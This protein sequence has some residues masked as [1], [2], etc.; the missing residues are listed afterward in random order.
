MW[1]VRYRELIKLLTIADLKLRYRSSAIGFAW[2]LLN[3]LLM[4]LI[5]YLVFHGVFQMKEN[6]FALYLLI[7][8]VAWRFLANGTVCSMGAVVHKSSLVTKLF[9]PRQILVFSAVLSCFVSSALEFLV[10]VVLLLLFGVKLSAY[11]FCFPLVHMVYFAMVYGI[12][13]VL[14]ALYVYYR[15]LQQIWEVLLQAGFFLSPVVYP[16]AVVPPE[17]QALY[18]AN[19][20][21]AVMQIY[22]QILLYGQAPSAAGMI[23]L[24][25]A[26]GVTLWLGSLTFMRLQRRFAE[27]L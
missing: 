9:I 25:T 21:T 13:L 2:T 6:H 10:L 18:L 11:F 22:R 14:A 27:E 17:Y 4:M 16:L 8:I 15:D 26:S 5:L 1:L 24:L 3:P 20:V 19:P 7:G 12:S 23:V